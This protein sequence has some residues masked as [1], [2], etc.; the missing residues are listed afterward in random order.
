MILVFSSNENCSKKLEEL[1]EEYTLNLK[2]HCLLTAYIIGIHNAV[3]LWLL[4]AGVPFR[5]LLWYSA[6][7]VTGAIVGC[8]SCRFNA[9]RSLFVG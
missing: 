6:A 5:G 9:I 2:F 3:P 4:Q 7:S 1:F 8:G